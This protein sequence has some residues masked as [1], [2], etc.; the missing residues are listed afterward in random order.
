V[1]A[2][3]GWQLYTSLVG[4]QAGAIAKLALLPSWRYCQ[5]GA[6][7]SHQPGRHQAERASAQLRLEDKIEIGKQVFNAPGM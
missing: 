7:S 4:C 5:V 6:I 1:I 3:T 2:R